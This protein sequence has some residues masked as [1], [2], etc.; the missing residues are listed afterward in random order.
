MKVKAFKVMPGV[1]H[2]GTDSS[3]IHKDASDAED[4]DMALAAQR[5]DDVPNQP[6]RLNA[7]EINNKEF[8]DK[9]AFSLDG[10]RHDPGHGFTVEVHQGLA[11]LVCNENCKYRESRFINPARPKGPPPPTLTPRPSTAPGADDAADA[12]QNLSILRGPQ[13]SDPVLDVDAVDLFPPAGDDAADGGAADGAGET[14]NAGGKNR[15]LCVM[16]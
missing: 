10:E 8:R 7:H 15:E 1:T 13:R 6:V 2:D 5:V 16:S 9:F 3:N 11:R 14:A 12:V 4:G